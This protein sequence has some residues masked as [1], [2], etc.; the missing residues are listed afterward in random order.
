[1]ELLPDA[2][3]TIR[4]LTGALVSFAECPY[5]PVDDAEYQMAAAH[6]FEILNY[7]TGVSVEAICDKCLLLA[8][9]SI[10]GVGVDTGVP[11]N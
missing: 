8:E 10:A 3:F 7:E 2:D 4:T 9:F 6:H 5:P 1:L 11:V